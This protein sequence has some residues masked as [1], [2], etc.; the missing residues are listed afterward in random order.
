MI[1]LRKISSLVLISYRD[2][3]L[4]IAMDIPLWIEQQRM[5]GTLVALTT[6]LHLFIT[7]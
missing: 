6:I 1:D 5:Q 7:L 3:Y 4:A 2:N